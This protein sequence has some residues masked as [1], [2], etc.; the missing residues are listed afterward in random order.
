MFSYYFLKFQPNSK[1]FQTL[2]SPF[3][4]SQ[5]YSNGTNDSLSPLPDNINDLCDQF[6]D[7]ALFGLGQNPNLSPQQLGSPNGGSNGYSNGLGCL[8]GF[9]GR[10]GIRSGDCGIGG[11]RLNGMI[12]SGGGGYSDGSGSLNHQHHMQ[13]HHHHHQQ[14]PLLPLNAQQNQKY[15]K[16]PPANYLCHLCF[17]KGHYIRDCPQVS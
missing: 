1:L 17:K 9:G 5:S 3:P 8:N 11:N 15:S 14:H 2:W 4:T 6:T 16:I 10:D 12:G 13:Q 7:L